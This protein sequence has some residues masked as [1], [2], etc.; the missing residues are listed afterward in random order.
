MFPG[1][2]IVSSLI[3]VQMGGTG[4]GTISLHDLFLQQ[5]TVMEVP[6]IGG[7][8]Q[9]FKWLPDNTVK[10]QDLSYSW[11]NDNN[12]IYISSIQ[13]YKPCAIGV[14]KNEEYLGLSSFGNI[15]TNC[16]S[17]YVL[18]SDYTE[19][20]LQYDSGVTEIHEYTGTPYTAYYPNY[21][22]VWGIYLPTIVYENRYDE[23]GDVRKGMGSS[24]INLPTFGTFYN[25]ITFPYAS[26]DIVSDRINEYVHL[27]YALSQ[28][29]S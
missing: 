3:A 23:S 4:G 24:Q 8:K 1:N 9:V 27:C 21:I 11:Y 16:Y 28:Q 12:L 20:Y 13:K 29:S 18:K 17:R 14:F 10:T 15:D 19:A 7:Y 22:A 6:L 25:G 26:A 5:E 2:D